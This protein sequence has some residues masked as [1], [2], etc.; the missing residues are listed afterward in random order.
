MSRRRLSIDGQFNGVIQASILP[1]YFEA[2]Y[3]KIGKAPGSYFSLIRDDGLILARY[4][5]L[6]EDTRL[7]PKGALIEAFRTHPAEGSV[8]VLSLVDGVK[9]RVDYL[10]LPE[11]PV[12]VLSGLETSAIWDAWIAR[13]SRDLIVGIP[14]I[15]TLVL[16]VALALRRTRRLYEEARRDRLRKER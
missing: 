12:Y 15:G 3:A 16:V 11:L 9:R 10:K 2:F 14:A 4:P 7:P 8:T 13:T 6:N 5:A 1:E